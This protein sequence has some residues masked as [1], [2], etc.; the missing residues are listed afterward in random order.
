MCDANILKSKLLYFN[1]VELY[2]LFKMYEAS[3]RD[4]RKL[5]TE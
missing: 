5:D 1:Y 2:Q 3:Q 4:K